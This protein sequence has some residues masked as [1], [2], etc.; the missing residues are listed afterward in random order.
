[1]GIPAPAKVRQPALFPGFTFACCNLQPVPLVIMYIFI[2]FSCDNITYL[3]IYEGIFLIL[4]ILYV[5]IDLELI[6]P[7][8]KIKAGDD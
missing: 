7:V 1:L 8:P 5:I 6:E 2:L 3:F 4:T